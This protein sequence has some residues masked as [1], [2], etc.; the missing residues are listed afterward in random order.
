MT[1]AS[2]TGEVRSAVP[3]LVLSPG[4]GS[5]DTVFSDLPPQVTI[6]PFGS[7]VYNYQWE[8]LRSFLAS[9]QAT[10]M[11]SSSSSPASLAFPGTGHD[12]EGGEAAGLRTTNTYRGVHKRKDKWVA[13]I[14]LPQTKNRVWLGTYDSPETAAHAYDRAAYRLLGECAHFNFPSVIPNDDGCPD[15]LRHLR[16]AVDAKIQAIPDRMARKHASDSKQNNQH[17]ESAQEE[18][19]VPARPVLSKSAATSSTTITTTTEWC[20]EGT[21]GTLSV[22]DAEWWLEDIPYDMELIWEAL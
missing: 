13:E 8:L 4:G 5:L 7:S 14:R 18:P 12:I 3:S 10:T 1:P 2:F 16:D 19:P 15:T 21:E 17:A 9:H 20:L 11:S 22:A 6:P